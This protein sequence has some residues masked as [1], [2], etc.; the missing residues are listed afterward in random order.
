L[1]TL[2]IGLIETIGLVPAIE[3]ADASLKAAGVELFAWRFTTGGLVTM[4]VKGEVGAVKAAIEA[5]VVAASKVGKVVSAHVIPRLDPQVLGIIDG[6]VKPDIPPSDSGR[7][8]TGVLKEAE[9]EEKRET[10]TS[11]LKLDEKLE[12][13]KSTVMEML[14]KAGKRNLIKDN[15]PLKDYGVKKLR[16]ILRTIGG[17]LIDRTAMYYMRKEELLRLLVSV[18]EEIG[19]GENEKY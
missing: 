10:P 5:G 9:E 14:N 3:A 11:E 15:V 2:A 18:V 8:D 4:I 16:V 13:I 6:R 7:K 19:R 17:N 12:Q 1:S